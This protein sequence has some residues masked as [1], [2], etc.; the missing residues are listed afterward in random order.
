MELQTSRKSK[1]TTLTIG[2]EALSLDHHLAKDES[3][4]SAY[5]RVIGAIA[6]SD[7]L[8]GLAE[9]SAVNEIANSADESAVATITL[10]NALER[11]S[12]LRT[13]SCSSRTQ[14]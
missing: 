8:V 6:S 9:Y 1:M 3:F 10:L 7:G 13:R 4:P 14:V 12:P 5:L 2:V 11:P